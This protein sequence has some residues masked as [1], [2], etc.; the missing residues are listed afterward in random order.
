M[1]FKKLI[2]EI[3]EKASEVQLEP[4]YHFIVNY[5]GITEESEDAEDE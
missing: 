4:L 3:L 1:K 5:I 2:V